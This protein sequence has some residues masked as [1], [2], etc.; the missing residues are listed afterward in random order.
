MIKESAFITPPNHTGFR[1]KVLLSKKQGAVADL[2]IA[3][4]LPE[5]GGPTK[6]H[7]HDHDHIFFVVYGDAKLHVGEEYVL[8]KE[9]EAYHVPGG[10]VHS[11]WNNGKGELKMLGINI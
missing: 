6:S 4:I 11:V 8:L 9:D 10:I 3:Y 2:S 7:T 1:A 5:G